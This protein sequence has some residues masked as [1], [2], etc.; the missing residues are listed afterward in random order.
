M[1]IQILSTR[2]RLL[3]QAT[4]DQGGIQVPLVNQKFIGRQSLDSET[5]QAFKREVS[6]IESN[7]RIDPPANRGR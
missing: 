7:D 5:S 2:D 4:A 6:L 1:N 3:Y